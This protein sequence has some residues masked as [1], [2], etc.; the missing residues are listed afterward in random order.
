M[1][2]EQGQSLTEPESAP[3]GTGADAEIAAHAAHHAPAGSTVF[4]DAST[5]ALALSRCLVEQVP[6]G[7]TMVTNSLAIVHEMLGTPM[8][9]LV[10]PG[11]VH[12]PARMIAGRLTAAFVARL[13]F[14]VAFV[15]ATGLALDRGL[16]TANEAAADVAIAARARATRAVGLLACGDFNRAA[17]AS[18]GFAEEFDAIVTDQ[19]VP[20]ALVLECVE[21]GVPLEI[22]L[23][24]PPPA[25][26][27]AFLQQA[28]DRDTPRRISELPPFAERAVSAPRRASCRPW[29]WPRIPAS[30][31]CR[32]SRR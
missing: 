4:L 10:C 32:G 1:R 11:T 17:A 9:V 23:A 26:G 31:T 7:L 14:D 27:A 6:G 15:S 28:N 21:A 12:Q 8:R 18:I 2:D 13:T 19:A 25:S 22:A 3:P 16:T 5:T 20:T 24:D 29:G 30:R